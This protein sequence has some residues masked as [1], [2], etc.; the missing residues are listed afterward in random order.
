VELDLTVPPH[1]PPHILIACPPIA[2]YTNDLLTCLNGLRLLAPKEIYHD[3]VKALNATL[4]EA[5]SRFLTILK[6]DA[7]GGSPDEDGE[8]A[9]LKKNAG[10]LFVR[11]FIRFVRRAL[12]EGVY[13]TENGLVGKAEDWQTDLDVVREWETWIDS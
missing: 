7:G 4:E 3:L 11:V 2:I 6:A 12:V 13:S 5:G 10:I 8:I 9:R 1:V